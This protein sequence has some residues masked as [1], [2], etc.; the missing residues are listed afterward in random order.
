V[1]EGFSH[2]DL[3]SGTPRTIRAARAVVLATGG[4]GG[5]PAFRAMQDPRLG[6]EL[7]TTNHPGATSEALR[8][9]LDIGCV[10]IQ[11]SWI[12]L[13]PWTSPDERGF[14][15]APTFVQG[16]TASYGLWVATETGERFVN[17]LA[18]RKTRADAIIRTGNRAIAF[19][20]A[21]GWRKGM[22][23]HAGERRKRMKESG[24]LME[25]DSLDAMAAAHD[26]PAE[27]LKE[28]V[29]RFNAAVA[30]GEDEAWGRYLPQDIA[31][32][33]EPP[34]YAVR[35]APKIHHTMGGVAI[36]TEAHALDVSTGEPIPGL[37]AAGE[38]TGGVHGASRLGSCAYADCLIFGRIAGRNAAA[39]EPWS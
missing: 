11:P 32:I 24:V 15:M 23:G 18:D 33:G 3:D 31:P 27:R 5:D 9:A 39:M 12:Q 21:A 37:F 28:T 7:D 2:P 38:V 19:V 1:H 17:E 36:D 25:Y 26:I 8:E 6:G 29:E 35:L 20:D 30:A 34:F 4:F 22:G 14:G 16:A 13:G 10:L